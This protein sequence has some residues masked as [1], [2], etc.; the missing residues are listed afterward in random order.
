MDFTGGS[1]PGQRCGVRWLGP[2]FRSAHLSSQHG[3][4]SSLV[5]RR[6]GG[7][8]LSENGPDSLQCGGLPFGPCRSG[9][10]GPQTSELEGTSGASSC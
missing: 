7:Q 2:S 10:S 3:G 9:F 8:I 4:F 6:G 5:Q 1:P